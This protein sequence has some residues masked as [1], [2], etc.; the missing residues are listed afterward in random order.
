MSQR[1]S[2]TARPAPAH[3]A[4]VV[5]PSLAASIRLSAGHPPAAGPASQDDRALDVLEPVAATPVYAHPALLL[6]LFCGALLLAGAVVYLGFRLT[7]G[8]V[9]PAPAPP[10]EQKDAA[11]K[12]ARAEEITAKRMEGEEVEAAGPRLPAPAHT[13][14]DGLAPGL[15][16]TLGRLE[17]ALERQRRF[18]SDASHELRTPLTAMR[19]QIEDALQAPQETDAA[20]LARALLP[21]LD[22]LQRIATD[23]LALSRLESDALPVRR[24]RVD[25][26]KLAEGELR[27]L[28]ITKRTVPL[29]GPDVVVMGDPDSLGSLICNLIGNAQRHAASTVTV[30]VW[31]EPRGP[32]GPPGGTAVLEVA[33]DGPGIP[34]EQ[35][36]KVFQRFTRLDSA[37]SRDAGGAGLG[38]AIARQ[39]AQN[40]GGRLTIEDSAEGARF[41]LQLPLAPALTP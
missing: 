37:R 34:R 15:N 40:H 38:L 7:G 21:S 14:I 24:Q 13:E 28:P 30:T 2:I 32:G 36:E 33:D 3:S 4:A 8:R 23:L 41:V 27:T 17:E 22:R 10:D 1:S 25:L 35:R 9:P 29:L 19:T 11:P 39:V 31:R 16:R 26:G 5:P 18:S 6:V 12:Q 20:T